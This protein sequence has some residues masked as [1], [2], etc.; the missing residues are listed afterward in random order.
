MQYTISRFKTLQSESFS[1]SAELFAELDNP[2]SKWHGGMP[3]NIDRL[4][5]TLFTTTDYKEYRASIDAKQTPR[6]K[7]LLAYKNEHGDQPKNVVM[8]D[9]ESTKA[10]VF[11]TTQGAIDNMSHGVGRWFELSDYPNKREFMEEAMVYALWQISDPTPTLLFKHPETSF[12][13]L[14]GYDRFNFFTDTDISSSLWQILTL[15]D[16]EAAILEAYLLVNGLTDGSFTTTYQ[17]AKAQYLGYFESPV[18]YAKHYYSRYLHNLPAVMV[19]HIDF[20]G[21]AVIAAE[22]GF[23]NKGHYFSAINPD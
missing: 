6:I 22:G 1:T 5:N 3:A 8:N 9:T 19:D 11:V 12:E 2:D 14:T 17:Q 23:N 18:A 7:H 13:S 4:G 20:N 21:L 15:T 10:K 16:K